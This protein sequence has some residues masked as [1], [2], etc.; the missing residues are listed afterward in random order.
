MFIVEFG[1]RSVPAPIETINIE[2]S[3]LIY[4]KKGDKF[5]TTKGEV[6]AKYLNTFLYKQLFNKSYSNLLTINKT[7]HSP[8]LDLVCEH[9]YT[10]KDMFLKMNSSNI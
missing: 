8:D 5:Q 3:G 7:L 6:Q 2:H 10:L 1:D 4:T 9:I